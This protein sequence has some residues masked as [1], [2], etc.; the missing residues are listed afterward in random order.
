M[1][2]KALARAGASLP[3]ELQE[4]FG[5]YVDRDR[6]AAKTSAGGW[7]WISLQGGLMTIGDRNLGDVLQCVVLGSIKEKTYFAGKYQPGKSAPPACF[8][9]DI[10]GDEDIMG[11]PPEL[12]SRKADRCIDCDFNVFGSAE[13][14]R[15]KA[16]RDHVRL[17]LIPWEDGMGVERIHEIEGARLRVPPTSLAGFPTS[18]S[19]YGREITGE[20]YRRPLF[21]VVTAIGVEKDPRTQ[22]K[23]H[24]RRMSDIDDFSL[25]DALERR[26]IAAEEQRIQLPEI[27]GQRDGAEGEG[28]AM[29]KGR[30]KRRVITRGSSVEE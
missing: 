4:R 15:G 1:T 19:E 23:V 22:F 26:V 5:K 30:T 18:F 10:A 24:F 14:G 13:N 28:E 29:A 11:P 16:C 27:G 8:A 6:A 9:L 20:E 17:V 3:S 12:E 21:S 2:D 7:P 25:L